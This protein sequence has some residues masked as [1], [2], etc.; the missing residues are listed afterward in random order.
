MQKAIESKLDRFL[1]MVG[2]WQYYDF[3]F[4][5][6]FFAAFFAAFLGAAFFAAFLGAAFFAAFFGAAVFAAALGAA[7]FAAFLAVF[8]ATFL[9]AVFAAFFLATV[10]PP[11]RAKSDCPAAAYR[12]NELTTQVTIEKWFGLSTMTG[13]ISSC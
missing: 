10:D 11:S 4:P 13:T 7:F 9:A 12:A 2:E 8:F 5:A 6:F 3:F 1:V